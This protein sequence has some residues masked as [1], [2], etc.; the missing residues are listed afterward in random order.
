MAMKSELSNRAKKD[1][2]LVLKAK[3]GD[4]GAYAMLLNRYWDSIFFMLLK[5]V[6]NK[7]DAED[8]TIEAFGKAFKNLQY[9]EPEF[10]FSTWLFKI[11]NNNTIDFIRRQK[12]KTVTIDNQGRNPE[13]ESLIQLQSMSPDPEE[14]LIRKQKAILLKEIVDELKPRYSRLVNLRYYK[15]YSYEEIAKELILPLGTVKAQLF[16]AKELLATI[17]RNK[18]V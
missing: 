7:D 11:A 17:L 15:E 14:E 12:G 2:E 9:Y 16:R 3:A 10:A 6:H 8:L 4:Q 18:D 1:Y 13:E 5:M